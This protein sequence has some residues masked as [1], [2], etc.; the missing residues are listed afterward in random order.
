MTVATAI[1]I[2]EILAV[3]LCGLV[4][5][6]ARGLV[7]ATRSALRAAWGLVARI[8]RA[9]ER[10]RLRRLAVANGGLPPVRVVRAGAVGGGAWEAH[11]A[12]PPLA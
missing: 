2:A 7:R 11:R 3:Y 12:A 1:F 4:F 9:A 6:V 5:L 10:R 8:R